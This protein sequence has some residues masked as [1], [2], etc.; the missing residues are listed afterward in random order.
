MQTIDYQSEIFKNRLKKR[1]KHLLKWAKRNKI[2]A[3]RLYDKDIPEIPV[4]LDIYFEH[5]NSQDKTENLETDKNSQNNY[6]PEKTFA[7]LFLYKRPYEKSLEEE[8]LW[9]SG[10]I[11]SIEYSLN[12]PKE[13]IFFKMREKQKG[14]SQYEKLNSSQKKLIVKEGFCLFY[15]NPKDY[16]DTGLFLD[17]R[18]CRL[19]IFEEA[20]NKNILNLYAYTGSFSVQALAGGA[21]EIVSVDLSNTYL[22]WAKEN[23]RL[24]NLDE[25]KAVFIKS[26][27]IKF[28]E[29]AIQQNKKWDIIICDPPT[30]SNSKSAAVFDINRDWKKLCLL[31]LSVLDKNGVLYFSSNSQKIKFDAEILAKEFAKHSIKRNSLNQAEKTL[32]IKDISLQSIPED[33]RNKKIHRMWKISKV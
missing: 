5:S 23:I 18:P 11:D 2:F 16:L 1:F 14:S 26:C 19:K 28:L 31:C 12:I 25:K 7:V 20:R 4:A 3:F 15:I 32:L 30:F 13:R 33:F 24:N 21:S 9:V 10:I 17:H 27:A 8:K 22:N 6:L 29:E